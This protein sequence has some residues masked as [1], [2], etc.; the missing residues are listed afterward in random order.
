M[1]I[2]EINAHHGKSLRIN[3]NFLTQAGKV[4]RAWQRARCRDQA[5]AGALQGSGAAQL[6]IREGEVIA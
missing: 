5:L 2:I 3:E 4:F 1:Q 6:G